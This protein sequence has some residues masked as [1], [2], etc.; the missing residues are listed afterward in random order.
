MRFAAR[1]ALTGALAAVLVQA[2]IQSSYHDLPGVSKSGGTP[3]SG[4]GAAR[5]SQPGKA[6]QGFSVAARSGNT[7]QALTASIA[8]G[9]SAKA[10]FRAAMR[11]ISTYFDRSP[12]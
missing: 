11:Q 3:P 12:A 6:P 1:L 2:Q 5:A 9:T 4:A 8:S 7:G 10:A